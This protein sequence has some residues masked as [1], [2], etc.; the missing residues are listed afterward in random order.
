MSRLCRLEVRSSNEKSLLP[1]CLIANKFAQRIHG[2]GQL[3]EGEELESNLLHVAQRSIGCPSGSGS[4]KMGGSD[5][6]S[7]VRQASRGCT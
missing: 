5:R 1:L 2:F 3:A 4:L 7:P 6:N